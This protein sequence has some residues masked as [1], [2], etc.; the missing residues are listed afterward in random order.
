MIQRSDYIEAVATQGSKKLWD[1]EYRIFY[2][3]FPVLDGV[4]V[5]EEKESFWYRSDG[6]AEAREIHMTQRVI[7][8]KRE[9]K[10]V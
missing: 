10:V 5:E 7:Y 9:L 6:I 4:Y 3:Y 2:E 8:N 1:S